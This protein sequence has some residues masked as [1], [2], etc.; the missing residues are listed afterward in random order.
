MANNVSNDNYDQKE[1]ASLNGDE[2]PGTPTFPH[3]QYEKLL[4]LIQ[5]SST[6]QQSIS[7]TNQIRSSKVSSS[8]QS[9]NTPIEN[10]KS[11]NIFISTS[12]NIFSIGS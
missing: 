11:S 10:F 1:F 6:A 3:E 12:N 2:W 7:D 4:N 5:S 9:V 8:T